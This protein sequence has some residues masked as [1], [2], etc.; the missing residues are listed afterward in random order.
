[1]TSVRVSWTYDFRGFVAT[2]RQQSEL[3]VALVHILHDCIRV[4]SGYPLTGIANITRDIDTI[5]AMYP[6][7]LSHHKPSLCIE[8]RPEVPHEVAVELAPRIHG[9][10]N[11][12][13][14]NIYM[15]WPSTLAPAIDQHFS[16]LRSIGHMF[17]TSKAP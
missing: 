5:L 15:R 16:L 3:Q 9:R 6:R 14:T 10:F 4:F 1:M 11:D 12:A 7:V 8:P 13:P 2:I 17:I